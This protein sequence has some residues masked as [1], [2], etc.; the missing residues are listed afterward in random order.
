M[1]HPWQDF[2]VGLFSIIALAGLAT[3]L[4]FFGELTFLLESRYSLPLRAN[5]AS[6]LR[7]GSQVMLE[8]VPVGEVGEISLDHEAALPVRIVLRVDTRHQIPAC[9]KPA[10]SAGLLGGGSR[11]DLRIPSNGDPTVMIDQ[12][13]PAPIDVRFTSFG[14]QIEIILDY[15]TNGQGTIGRLLND[16]SLYDNMADSAQRL[17]LT[18]RDLQ[19]LVRKVKEEGIDLKF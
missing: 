9:V 5:A 13:N 18:L 11:I 14:E 12:S 17:T 15:L 6:G 10:I 7:V 19:I 8:G 3:L 1:R 2:M 16:S 4:L